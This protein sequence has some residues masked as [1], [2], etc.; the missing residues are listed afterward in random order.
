[1]S[2]AAFPGAT[3]SFDEVVIVETP[4]VRARMYRCRHC[5]HG[6]VAMAVNL[7]PAVINAR[8]GAC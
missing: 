7:I 8:P 3:P 1:L 4:E 6:T 2:F 5:G